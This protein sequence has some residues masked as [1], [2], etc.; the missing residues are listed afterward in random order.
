MKLLEYEAKQLLQAHQ[1]P[2]PAGR[3]VRDL[4]GTPPAIW[5][6]MLKVQIPVGGRGKAGGIR[7]VHSAAEYTATARELLGRPLLGHPVTVLLSED[8]LDIGRELYLALAVDRTTSAFVLL[9]HPA[10]GIE[11]E[12]AAGGGSSP[13]LL[14]LALPVT[15]PPDVAIV[16]RVAQHLSL[17]APH[18][19][20][21]AAVLAGLWHVARTQDALLVEVNPLVLTRGG[22]LVCADA[23][24][25]LD[26]AAVFRHADWDFCDQP[27]PAQFV[28]LS[29]TGTIASIANGAGLAMATVDAIK[30]AGA[31]PANFCDVGGGTNE[32]GLV[33]AFSQIAG[34][35]TV[36]AVV[37]NIFGGITRCDEVARAIIT[38][39]AT[40][41]GLPPL[42]I[43]LVGTN[44][45][46]AHAILDAAGLPLLPT[47]DACVAQAVAAVHGPRPVQKSTARDNPR[48]P[49][50]ANPHRRS[51]VQA[52]GVRHD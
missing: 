52:P 35:P 18:H 40:R 3:L 25:E 14:R 46:T 13:Q 22:R 26:D 44:A 12:T 16:R 38:A 47:L 37:V 2:L 45:E 8:H 5:P 4:A 7:A 29:Q 31:E 10:G 32:A 17:D 27:A 41:A 6:Q 42:F 1:L 48:H 33:R 24:I 23:K 20:E 39:G 9:A 34:L 21:L 49:A 15:A 30:A 50:P 11:I 51:R 43:R 28:T 36:R 19:D